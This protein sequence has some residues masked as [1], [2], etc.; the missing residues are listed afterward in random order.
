[1]YLKGKVF[2]SLFDKR[3]EMG[4]I[5]EMGRSRQDLAQ[6]VLFGRGGV[7]TLGMMPCRISFLILN[8][9]YKVSQ[10]WYCLFLNL[11]QKVI[12]KSK[13]FE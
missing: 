12:K 10:I 8:S 4:R 5:F 13:R 9:L 1:M 11:F 6:V 2:N 7:V 3:I